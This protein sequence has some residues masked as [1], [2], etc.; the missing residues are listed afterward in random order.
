MTPADSLPTALR[1]EAP[2]HVVMA[3]GGRSSVRDG[4]PRG[5]PPGGPEPGGILL[6]AL[7]PCRPQSKLCCLQ[8][9]LTTHEAT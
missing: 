8:C 1:G 4:G 2:G 3:K 7:S 6:V 5:V 9:H